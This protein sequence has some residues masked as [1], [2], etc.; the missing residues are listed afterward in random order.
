VT[1]NQFENYVLSET[2]PMPVGS[3]IA[4]EFLA[5]GAEEAYFTEMWH[6]LVLMSCDL[7]CVAITGRVA[8]FITA[9]NR[10][11]GRLRG[12]PDVLAF[13]PDG[14][15]SLREAKNAGAKDKLQ[16]GQHEFARAARRVFGS[17]VDFGVIEWGH[18]VRPN[19]SLQ[20]TPTAVMP[21]A[22][23]EIMPAVGVAEH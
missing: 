7:V 5:V 10:E 16:Q 18:V 22:A 23:Q 14:R 21:P 3:I 2:G 8:A 11:L 15:I 20:P 19:K 9:M 17:Q 1:P 12:L 6:G 4:K 13:F